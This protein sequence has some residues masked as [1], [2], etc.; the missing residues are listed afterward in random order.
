MDAIH[1]K[2]RREPIK[3]INYK[4]VDYKFFEVHLADELLYKRYIQ[5]EIQEM[6]IRHGISESFLTKIA[7]LIEDTALNTS[8]IKK[9][10]SDMIAIAHNLQGRLGMIADR[11]MY[12][13]L[14][15][16]YF[17]LENE[18]DDI[19]EQ[20]NNL[21]KEIWR[22]SGEYDF[23]IFEVFKRINTSPNT[24]MSDLLAVYQAV[25]ERISQ[26]PTLPI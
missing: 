23:F 12:A 14:A 1:P 19:D 7:E 15:C 6:F 21:K 24:S 5:A 26:L 16:V 10:R 2:K 25:E 17:M 18:G 13:D 20:T 22:A 4:G 9:L 3:V 11:E 8:D